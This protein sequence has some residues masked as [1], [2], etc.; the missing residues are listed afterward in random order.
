MSDPKEP[1]HVGARR[2]RPEC[3]CKMCLSIRKQVEAGKANP[4]DQKPK[5]SRQ[6]VR[7]ERFVKAFAD[8]AKETFGNA[9]AAAVEA[10]YSRNSA[11]SQG[12]RLLADEQV[13]NA[14][15]AALT[16][17]GITPEH[18]A[19]RAMEGLGAERVQYFAHQGEV[20]DQRIDPDYVTRQKYLEMLFRLRGDFPAGDAGPQTAIFVKIG[21]GPEDEAAW[22]K[23]AEKMRQRSANQVA[24][25]PDRV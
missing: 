11:A 7:R 10:G 22:N 4:A 6:I 5:I 19:Q 9:T 2:H 16:A 24:G 18:L 12:S 23:R 21:S 25:G 15:V 1:R 8:P 13:Q 20:V 14:V 17:V 3:L